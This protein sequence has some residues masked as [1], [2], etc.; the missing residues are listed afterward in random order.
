MKIS[1]DHSPLLQGK[2]Y[3][4]DVRFPLGKRK[5]HTTLDRFSF[6]KEWSSNKNIIHLGCCDHLSCIENNHKNGKWLQDWL[7]ESAKY[8]LGV[9]IGKETVKFVNEELKLENVICADLTCEIPQEILDH[10]WD[11]IILSEVIEHID[12]PQS[13]LKQLRVQL[14]PYTDTLI[15]TAPNALTRSFKPKFTQIEHINS[16]HRFYFSPYTLSRLLVASGYEPLSF[17]FIDGLPLYPA[18]SIFAKLKRF[19]SVLR[20]K[21]GS[22]QT[23]ANILII[24]KLS[25]NIPSECIY[26]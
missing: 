14:L 1:S 10:R 18:K 20:R 9:D 11:G 23:R 21:I 13:F 4:D 16:D 26:R 8:C 25:N 17:H 12:N 5:D 19:L 6:L 24:A 15:I 2:T 3:C 22:P 7:T